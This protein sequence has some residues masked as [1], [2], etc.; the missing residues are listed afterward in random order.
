MTRTG[1]RIERVE[2]IMKTRKASQMKKEKKGTP[3]GAQQRNLDGFQR[4]L[5]GTQKGECATVRWK[6]PE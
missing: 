1:L 5:I 4:D 6:R 3:T 2:K